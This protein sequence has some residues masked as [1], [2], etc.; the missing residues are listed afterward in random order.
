MC[1][2]K[3]LFCKII[4]LMYVGAQ[5]LVDGLEDNEALEGGAHVEP[6]AGLPGGVAGEDAIAR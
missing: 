6:A 5:A 3:N 4:R 1:K 2:S